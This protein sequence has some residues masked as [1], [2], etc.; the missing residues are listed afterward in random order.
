MLNIRPGN[1]SFILEAALV[2][3]LVEE[4]RITETIVPGMVE[5]G[6]TR[7]EKFLGNVEIVVYDGQM[8]KN[9]L[10]RIFGPNTDIS[11]SDLAPEIWKSYPQLKG[12]SL[13]ALRDQSRLARYQTAS[14]TE[15]D[16]L[17]NLFSTYVFVRETRISGSFLKNLD[18]V[19]LG[20]P[21]DLMPLNNE[22]RILVRQ[23]METLNSLADRLKELASIQGTARR[24]LS[25]TDVA[26]QLTPTINAAGRLGVPEK[27]VELFLTKDDSRRKVLASEIVSLNEDR[28]RLGE[29]AWESVLPQAKRSYEELQEKFVLVSGKNIHR[30]ITGIICTRLVHMFNVPALTLAFMDNSIAGSVRS[31]KGFYVK[32]FISQFSDLFVDYGGHDYAQVSVWKQEIMT[33]SGQDLKKQFFRWKVL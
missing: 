23:G 32:D 13:F 7:L 28:K 22:N 20:T 4:D 11:L 21:A 18:L 30:G 1:D 17:I 27:A 12:K 15:L 25:T 2:C 5:F 6:K 29:T 31:A 10:K 24:K 8:H 3:N 14:P 19:A 33:R 26:W 9:M 16:I